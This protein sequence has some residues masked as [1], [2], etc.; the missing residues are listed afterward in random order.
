M[1][2]RLQW[3]SEQEIAG[4]ET[5]TESEVHNITVS[6]GSKVKVRVEVC[7]YNDAL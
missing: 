5:G 4:Y 1:R 7:R 6:R 3:I 2:R